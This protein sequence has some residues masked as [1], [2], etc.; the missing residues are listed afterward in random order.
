MASTVIGWRVVVMG[1]SRIDS[2][3]HRIIDSLIHLAAEMESVHQCINDS[4]VQWFNGSINYL[5]ILHHYYSIRK[6]AGQFMIVRDEQNREPVARDH[7]TQ[8]R[9]QFV[10]ACRV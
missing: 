8:Q 2:L 10:R 6:A 4:M 1:L 7:F 9:K 3:A 5:S